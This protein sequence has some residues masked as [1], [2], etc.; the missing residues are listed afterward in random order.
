MVPI[1]TD[2]EEKSLENHPKNEKKSNGRNPI[3]SK[4][5]FYYL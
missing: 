4:S 5:H 1:T 2:C 3:Y